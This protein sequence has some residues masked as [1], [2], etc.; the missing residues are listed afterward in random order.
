MIAEYLIRQ[1]FLDY[2][3]EMHEEIVELHTGEDKDRESEIE[4]NGTWFAGFAA[5][6]HE[7]GV[8]SGDTLDYL[9]NKISEK[10]GKKK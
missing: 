8:I 10:E 2:H 4:H 7:A 9:T 1:G 5:G 6:L 3:N